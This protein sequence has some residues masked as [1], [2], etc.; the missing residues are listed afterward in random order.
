MWGNVEDGGVPTRL[1]LQTEPSVSLL[2]CPFSLFSL[3]PLLHTSV[4]CS[5]FPFPL[6]A[7][8]DRMA[9]C[10]CSARVPVLWTA[11]HLGSGSLQE[12]GFPDQ[13][14]KIVRG[15]CSTSGPALLEAPPRGCPEIWCL[16]LKMRPTMQGWSP[17]ARG[18]AAQ[19]LVL[20]ACSQ[21]KM[22][23]GCSGGSGT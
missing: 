20:P 13:Q 12:P 18:W 22:D 14:S 11:P 1:P 7:E 17:E 21:E 16:P 15:K 2:F 23:V 5:N 8:A 3:P 9:G 6:P 19:R 10:L 4:T